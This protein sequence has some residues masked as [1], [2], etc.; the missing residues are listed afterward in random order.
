MKKGGFFKKIKIRFG[1]TSAIL[2]AVFAVLIAVDLILKTCEVKYSW[3][4]VV[5]PNFIEVESGHL[6][7]GAAFSFLGD[8]VWGRVF[9]IVLTCI[10]FVAVALAFLF[11]PERFVAFKTALAMIGA[12]AVGNL[13]DRFAFGAVRDFVWMNIFGSFACCNFADFWI[14]LG[15]VLAIVDTLFFNEWAPM[16]LTKGAKSRVAAREKREEEK[17]ALKESE[18]RSDG[19]TAAENIPQNVGDNDIENRESAHNGESGEER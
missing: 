16:P 9:L 18:S 19:D 12:G 13:V 4:F 10:M 17:K 6:N 15:V 2:L 11:L 5:I 7:T 3:N 1:K 14:V 8:A